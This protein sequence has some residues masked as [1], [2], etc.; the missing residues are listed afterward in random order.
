MNTTAEEIPS[1]KLSADNAE[2]IWNTLITSITNRWNEDTGERKQDRSKRREQEILRAALRIFARDG[3]SRA[4]IGDI[5]S[6]AG[7]PV[8]SIYEYFES[9]EELAYAVPIAHFG[10]FY[11]EYTEAVAKKKTA[12]DRLR[13]YLWLAADYARRNPEWARTLYLEIW[14][15]VLLSETKVRHSIDDYARVIVYLIRQGGANG[16]WPAD[17]NPYETA[18]ILS[19]SVNQVITI[20]LLYRKP[21]D[22][23]KAITSVINR[24]M[25]LLLPAK[26]DAAKPARQMKRNGKSS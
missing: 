13:L 19:G 12:G 2:N 6:E 22:L 20:W 23:M 18:A 14:P 3:I 25:T 11:A 9:K 24:T 8:S 26:S 21:N 1:P 4:R 15:S 10:R 7:M 5:A 17:A 16:E